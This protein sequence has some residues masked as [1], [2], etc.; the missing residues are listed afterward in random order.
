MD[1]QDYV[2]F[3][4]EHP[5]CHIVGQPTKPFVQPFRISA[6]EAHFWTMTDVLREPELERI[7]FGPQ[8]SF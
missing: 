5:F 8:G 4:N 7:T 1:L 3:A 6:G 2:D